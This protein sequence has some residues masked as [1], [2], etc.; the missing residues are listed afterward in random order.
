VI[1]LSKVTTN[2]K[3]FVE[4]TESKVSD[5]WNMLVVIVAPSEGEVMCILRSDEEDD[6]T[7]NVTSYV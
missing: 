3:L 7:I 6:R 1:L 4:G 2:L 5:T